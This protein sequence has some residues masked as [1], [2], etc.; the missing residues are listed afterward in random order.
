[1]WA[2]ISCVSSALIAVSLGPVA[3]REKQCCQMQRCVEYPMGL[4]CLNNVPAE[5]MSDLCHVF[6]HIASMVVLRSSMVL[7]RAMWP[8]MI[9]TSCPVRIDPREIVPRRY[10]KS[11]LRPKCPPL[12]CWHL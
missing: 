2:L 3:V 9:C 8:F 4:L 12:G 10:A 6:A 7:S 1:M 11:K 5:H